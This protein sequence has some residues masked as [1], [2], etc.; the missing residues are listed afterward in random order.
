MAKQQG[1]SLPVEYQQSNQCPSYH[2]SIKPSENAQRRPVSSISKGK[3]VN[4]TSQSKIF[5]SSNHPSSG[6][7]KNSLV[8]SKSK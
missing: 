4:K 3:V 7:Q 2:L 8:F 5:S 1:I 6:Q